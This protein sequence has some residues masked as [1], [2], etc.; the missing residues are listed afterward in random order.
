MH[1]VK[2]SAFPAIREALAMSESN[3]DNGDELWQEVD[4]QVTLAVVAV[5]AAVDLLTDGV[6][7]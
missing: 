6:M 3:E 7:V 5:Q 2:G 4:R 1:S